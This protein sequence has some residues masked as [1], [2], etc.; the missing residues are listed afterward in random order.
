ML[1]GQVIDE[2]FDCFEPGKYSYS[3]IWGMKTFP[4]PLE[5]KL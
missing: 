1:S 5:K 3:A 4:I 2:N